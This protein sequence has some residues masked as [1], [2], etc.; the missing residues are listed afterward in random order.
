MFLK[1]NSYHLTPQ[2]KYTV[3]LDCIFF[4]RRGRDSKRRKP[5]SVNYLCLFIFLISFL[6]FLFIDVFLFLKEGS[7]FTSPHIKKT[8]KREFFDMRRGRDSN[9]REA[10]ASTSLAGMRFQPLS[11]LSIRYSIVIINLITLR[12]DRD[13]NPGYP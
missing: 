4:L 9:P 12:R 3:Y 10:F 6:Y 1:E 2:K 5:H 13:S 7:I 11:H 8:P